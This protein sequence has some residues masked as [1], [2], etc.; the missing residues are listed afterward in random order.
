MLLKTRIPDCPYCEAR[1]VIEGTLTATE[2]W[3]RYKCENCG[4]GEWIV[5]KVKANI[6]GE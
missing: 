6:E 1:L 3:S 5:P 4:Y 2:Q